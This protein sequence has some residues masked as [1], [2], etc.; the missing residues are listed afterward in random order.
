MT[1]LPPI[2]LQAPDIGRWKDGG[3]GVDWMH[4]GGVACVGLEAPHET[5]RPVGERVDLIQ[6]GDGIGASS[7]EED[8]GKLLVNPAGRMQLGRVNIEEAWKFAQARRDE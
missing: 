5:G 2:E 4:V 3:T 7:H 1:D 8:I 6:R